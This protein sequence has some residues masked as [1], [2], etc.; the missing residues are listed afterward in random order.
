[1]ILFQ[2]TCD[3][4]EEADVSEICVHPVH[5]SLWSKY[6]NRRKVALIREPWRKDPF[7]TDAD[8]PSNILITKDRKCSVGLF[9]PS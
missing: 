6:L 2:Q 3:T 1:M 4:K 8:R 7:S 5:F 9:I